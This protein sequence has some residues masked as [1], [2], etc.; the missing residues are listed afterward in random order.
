ME[1]TRDVNNE[2]KT[3]RTETAKSAESRV[4][5]VSDKKTESRDTESAL[6][7]EKTARAESMEHTDSA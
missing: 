1:N 5:A 6:R 7:G 4:N 2:G 3:G